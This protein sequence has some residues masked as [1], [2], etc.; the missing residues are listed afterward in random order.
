MCDNA[1]LRELLTGRNAQWPPQD[2]LGAWRQFSALPSKLRSA[3]LRGVDAAVARAQSSPG[4]VQALRE[5]V[6]QIVRWRG[7]RGQDRPESGRE[8]YVRHLQR[9]VLH[10]L[11]HEAGAD[12]AD[13]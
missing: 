7:S 11:T 13:D 12:S 4:D 10:K 2:V 6:N 1:E 8:Q 3:A 9:L 5:V